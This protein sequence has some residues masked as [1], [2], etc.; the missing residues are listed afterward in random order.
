M[1]PLGYQYRQA[2]IRPPKS[3]ALVVALG[4][5]AAILAFALMI[6]LVALLEVVPYGLLGPLSEFLL[7]S[8]KHL[9]GKG[10]AASTRART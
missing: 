1:Q 2:R 8:P 6:K 5:L 3:L 9:Q 4:V 10:T 7:E